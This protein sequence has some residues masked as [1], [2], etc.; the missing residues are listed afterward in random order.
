MDPV[1]H[2]PQCRGEALVELG[3]KARR[4]YHSGRRAVA[5]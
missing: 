4:R 2:S 1:D 3:R 5:A